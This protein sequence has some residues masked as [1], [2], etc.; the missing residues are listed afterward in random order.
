[1]R[2]MLHRTVVVGLGLGLGL[3]GCADAAPVAPPA[4]PAPD[5]VAH[6]AAAGPAGAPLLP[7]LQTVVP[8]QLQLVN[9]HKQELL[10]FSNGI[11]NTG[12]GPL[13]LRP[14][15]P[16]DGGQ[17]TQDAVQSIFDAGGAV[18][19]EQVVS[20]FEFHPEHNHWHIDAVALFELRSG[21]PTGPVVGGQSV[22]TTFCLVDWYK[23][24]G[25]SKTPER[26]YF[27]C[28]RESPYQGI[29][30]GWVDQYHQSV[31]GQQLVLTGAP[32]GL[33]YLVSTANPDGTFLESDLANNTAW[34]AFRLRRESRGN[35]KIEIVGRSPCAGALCGSPTNR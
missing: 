20:R 22:K 26:T 1:M 27:D 15:F 9:A 4:P 30:P 18:V 2:G 10:R 33:Y 5:P 29:S 28:S 32:P 19:R 7:D 11:A 17:T 24:E 34:V 21:S 8:Q 31:P 13:H 6:L 12:A 23:L 25:P 35:P 16:I 3:L 14:V